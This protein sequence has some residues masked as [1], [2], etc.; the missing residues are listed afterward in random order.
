MGLSYDVW[1]GAAG[2]FLVGVKHPCGCMWENGVGDR[3]FE[4]VWVLG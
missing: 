1:C 4:G 3:D 2:V